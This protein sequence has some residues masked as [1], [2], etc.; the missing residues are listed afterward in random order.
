[1]TVRRGEDERDAGEAADSGDSRGGAKG[2]RSIWAV[3][4]SSMRCSWRRAASS[5]E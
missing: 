3:R 5:L 4:Y 1:M 2:V